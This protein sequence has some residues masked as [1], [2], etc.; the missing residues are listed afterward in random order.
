MNKKSKSVLLQISAAQGPWECCWVVTQVA[1]L[2]MHQAK[3]AGLKV[4][5]KAEK[6]V[7]KIGFDGE[8]PPQ[9]LNHSILLSVR[10]D[11][12]N[13]VAQWEGSVLWQ[14]QSQFRPG[15]KRKNWFVSIERIKEEQSAE[16]AQVVLRKADIQLQTFKASGPG[17]QNVNKRD[18]AVRLI[19]RPTGLSTTAREERS[20]LCNRELAL[21]KLKKL[22]EENQ[23]SSDLVADRL[24]REQ[25]IQLQRG[26]P[27][28]IFIG[29]PL[30]EQN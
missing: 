19:H 5:V 7:Y 2:L 14:G 18:T 1:A 11:Y 9:G 21:A 28:K 8:V 4:T 15:H 3:D 12:E 25:Q 13:F 27:I 20:Q 24:K 30:K 6:P 10:G 22:V 26:N 29:F 16:K 17:G 23:A